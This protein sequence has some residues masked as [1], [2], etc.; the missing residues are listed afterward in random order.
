MCD[1]LITLTDFGRRPGRII[2]EARVTGEPVTITEYGEPVAT[3]TPVPAQKP[4]AED[5]QN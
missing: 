4:D 2:T 3:L 1:V 5:P